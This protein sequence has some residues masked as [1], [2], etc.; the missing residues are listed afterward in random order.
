MQNIPFLR[1]SRL[2]FLLCNT[3][4]RVIPVPIPH[5]SA[6]SVTT[7][8][9]PVTTPIILPEDPEKMKYNVTILILWA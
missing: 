1:L 5:S 4:T 7:A 6:N 3:Y 9:L 2:F 8:A